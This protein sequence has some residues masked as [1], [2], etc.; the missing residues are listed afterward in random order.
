MGNRIIM[1]DQSTAHKEEFLSKF[2]LS[3]Y[4]LSLVFP[5]GARLIYNPFLLISLPPGNMFI[6]MQRSFFI[7]FT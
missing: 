7:P 4:S 6:P 2:I 5:Y 3:H 1:L